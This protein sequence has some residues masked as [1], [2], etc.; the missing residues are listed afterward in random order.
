VRDLGRGLRIE[1]F[2]QN[3]DKE[4]LSFAHGV[5]GRFGVGLKDALATF[6][7][8]NVQVAIRSKYGT[9]ELCEAQKHNFDRI[10]TLHVRYDDSPVDMAGTDVVLRGVSESDVVR[11][12]SLFLRFSEQEML[13]VTAYGEILR[14]RGADARVYIMGVLAN[15]EPNFLFSYNITSLTDAMK[16][17]LN[18]ERLNVGRTTYTDRLRSMLKA[19]ISPAVQ[20]ALANQVLA[21]A[22]GGQC[23]EIQWIDV[24][25][26]AL[27]L[28][29]AR[30]PVAYVTEDEL[31]GRPDV[32]DQMRRDGYTPVVVTEA[33]KAKLDDQMDSGGQQVRTLEAYEEEYNQSFQYRFVEPARLTPGERQVLSLTPRLLE[34]VGA[35]GPR[36]PQ[37]RVSETMR[38]TG[39]ET[40]GVWDPAQGAIIVKRSKLASAVEYAA[41]LLHEVA[42][43][44][45]GTADAT[46]AFEEVLTEYLGRA[47]A[48]A[49]R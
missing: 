47:S 10:T 17:Q 41:T 34:L 8:H 43:A 27:N 4:K 49:L 14:R 18:R 46:R 13:D 37:V 16:K 5:I 21:R 28:L 3:E 20:E 22:S 23:D 33:A 25:Q 39:D 44:V 40:G 15:E 1:H 7:R 11:A 29:H 38:I 45:T 42:H 36:A 32:V 31:S 2:T 12:K 6:H 35:A 30:R 19:A 9:Y 48:R 24:Y 26:H